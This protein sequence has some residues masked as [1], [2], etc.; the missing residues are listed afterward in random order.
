MRESA[1]PMEKKVG[2]T[3]E[4]C[5]FKYGTGFLPITILLNVLSATKY[6]SGLGRGYPRMIPRRVRRA[7]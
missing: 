5:M 7:S 6:S 4:I 2:V 3:S 1:N